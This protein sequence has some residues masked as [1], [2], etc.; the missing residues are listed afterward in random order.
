MQYIHVIT[1]ILYIN[2]N[3]EMYTYTYYSPSLYPSLPH[4]IILG[5][6]L[7]ADKTENLCCGASRKWFI[8]IP[9]QFILLCIG[10]TQ[11]VCVCIYIYIYIYRNNHRPLPRN[12]ENNTNMQHYNWYLYMCVCVCLVWHSDINQ[13]TSMLLP[14]QAISVPIPKFYS[15][16]AT[17]DSG[18]N[19]HVLRWAEMQENCWTQRNV[20]LF[21]CLHVSATTGESLS[22]NNLHST[23]II[24][25]VPKKPITNNCKNEPHYNGFPTTDY[26]YLHN[27]SW[28]KSFCY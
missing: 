10:F 15:R 13:G 11:D 21:G 25:G 14:L 16:N 8:F 5:Q 4:K 2:E 7:L 24:Q 23:G 1:P 27:I 19:V 3:A 26:F 17:R 20:V 12:L 28:S 22:S 18:W 9:I 6:Q